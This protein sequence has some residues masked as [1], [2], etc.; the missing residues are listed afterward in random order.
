MIWIGAHHCVSWF[1]LYFFACVY[2]FG[3]IYMCVRPCV[4][5]CVLHRCAFFKSAYLS[6]DLRMT[7]VPETELKHTRTHVYTHGYNSTHTPLHYMN[8]S[9]V[10]GGSDTWCSKLTIYVPHDQSKEILLGL[11]NYFASMY[12]KEP[13]HE[14]SH[15]STD[16]MSAWLCTLLKREWQLALQATWLL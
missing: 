6:L 8:Q 2:R 1:F 3:C 5:V 13:N 16:K 9:E 14:H 15:I 12:E 11:R 7:S 10:W 4:C